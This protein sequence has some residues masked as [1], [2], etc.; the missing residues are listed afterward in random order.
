MDIFLFNPDNDMALANFTPYYKSPGE[1]EVMAADLAILPMWFA[2]EGSA[3]KVPSYTSCEKYLAYCGD[4]LPSSVSVIDSWIQGHY[5]P[6]GWSPALVHYL[7][8]NGVDKAFLPPA[9]YLDD[10]RRLSGRQQ[11]VL[12]LDRLLSLEGTCGYTAIARNLD[13]IKI[14]LKDYSNIILKSPWSG[15]GRGLAH[16]TAEKWN[17]S[18]EGW[19]S[20]L[21]RTQKEIMM[22]PYY[23]RILDF[24][25]EFYAD[26][27]GH[28]SFVG[29]SLFETDSHGNYK[30]NF[31]LSDAEIERRLTAY[32]TYRC[33]EN[34]RSAL[35]DVMTGLLGNSYTGYLGVDMMICHD[36]GV[37]YVHPCV[38]INLRMNMG[39]V[40]HILYRNLL[41]EA[42]TGNF[43]VVHYSSDSEAEIFHQNMLSR[44]SLVT[45]NKRIR[46]GY[47]SLT[48]F[49]SETRYQAYIIVRP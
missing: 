8:Q 42:S 45:N 48:P 38:E 47:F 31:L 23:D 17:P 4:L 16:V 49:K 29:Y 11:T 35:L 22:E 6:W 13:E 32:T 18:L 1:I 36:N 43:H 27:E 20:R 39:V 15:S 9:G 14:F 30:S 5:F 28:L 26:G 21:L 10:L 2:P 40:S 34:I 7:Q 24:A 46:S 12:V 19:I 37:F 25:M 44:Y 33:L 41:D 3:V